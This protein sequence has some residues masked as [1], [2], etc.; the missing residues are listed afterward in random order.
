M[1]HQE[2]VELLAG[3]IGTGELPAA[4]V[5]LMICT[6]QRWDRVTARLITEI[7]HSDCSTPPI[8]MS[9]PRRFSPMSM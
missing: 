9:S 1:R 3:V 4:L 7:E 6:C 5:A 8:S 2:A